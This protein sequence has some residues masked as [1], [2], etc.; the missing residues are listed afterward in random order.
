MEDKIIKFGDKIIHC[1]E[2]ECKGLEGDCIFY[3]NRGG[4]INIFGNDN[5]CLR[6]IGSDYVV[7]KVEEE[8]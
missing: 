2:G 4:C 5:F 6:T 7:Y 8:K 3:F 1:K